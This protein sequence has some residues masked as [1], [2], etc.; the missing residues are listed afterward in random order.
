M[1]WEKVAIHNGPALITKDDLIQEMAFHGRGF[2]KDGQ[3]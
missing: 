1:L 2:V 3:V